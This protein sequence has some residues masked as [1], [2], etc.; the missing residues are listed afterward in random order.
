MMGGRLSGGNW[1]GVLM[2]AVCCPSLFFMGSRG[3][4][5]WQDVVI[6]KRFGTVEGRGGRVGF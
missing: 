2:G 6:G 5:D 3:W 4:I 1:S